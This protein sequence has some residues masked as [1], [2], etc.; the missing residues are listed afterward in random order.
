MSPARVLRF[1]DRPASSRQIAEAQLSQTITAVCHR[2]RR[3]YGGWR[4]HT[5]LALVG[6]H[7]GRKRVGRLNVVH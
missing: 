4:V 7:C 5:E 2:S 3:T 6:V 1:R